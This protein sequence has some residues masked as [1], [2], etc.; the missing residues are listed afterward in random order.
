[1]SGGGLNADGSA[2]SARSASYRLKYAR[3]R[4][5]SEVKLVL[6]DCLCDSRSQ[7]FLNV[8]RIQLI[9]C[10]YQSRSAN[11]L[12]VTFLERHTLA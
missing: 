8:A 7:C 9:I 4:L 11:L 5:P 2:S 6:M 1:M 12:S 3:A 10:G